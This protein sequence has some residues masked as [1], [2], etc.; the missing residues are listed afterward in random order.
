MSEVPW[1]VS[2][3]VSWLP[4]LI[5][6]GSMMW[7]ARSV[8]RNLTTREGISVAQLIEQYGRELKRSNDLFERALSDI[9]VR[10]EALEKRG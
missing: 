2:F 7:V 5:F 8:G 10:L 3:I 9:R 1:Y 4:L 6:I